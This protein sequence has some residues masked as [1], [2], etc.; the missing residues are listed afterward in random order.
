MLNRLKSDP[1][2][3]IDL[4]LNQ[5]LVQH[6]IKRARFL[7]ERGELNSVPPGNRLISIGEY[8]SDVHF[9]LTGNA[10]IHIGMKTIIESFGAGNHVGEIAALHVVPRS[11]TVTALEEM[12]VLR[13]GKVHF[14]A[15]LIEFPEAGFALARDLAKRLEIRNANV[16]KPGKKHRIFAISSSEALEV[17]NTGLDYFKREPTFEYAPWTAEIFHPGNYLMEDLEAELMRADFAVAIAQDDDIVESRQTR[18][19]TPRDN[20]IF[21]LGLFIGVLGRKRTI[22][23][24]PVGLQIKLPTDVSGITIVRYESDTASNPASATSAWREVSKQFTALIK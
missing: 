8:E 3:L 12:T 16:I 13:L 2:E 20:V 9:I 10:K 17:V 22:L 15:F 1:S 4:L 7:A 19:A 5:E 23:M 21:E 14:R 11:A 24:A 6:D 18:T